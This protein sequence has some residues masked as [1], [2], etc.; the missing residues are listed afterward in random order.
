MRRADCAA[1]PAMSVD[2]APKWLRSVTAPFR[3]ST[4]ASTGSIVGIATASAMNT[5]QASAAG[6]GKVQPAINASTIAGAV[7]VRRRLSNIFQKPIAVP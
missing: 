4:A 6:R 3:G 7:R 1:A 5:V 2:N